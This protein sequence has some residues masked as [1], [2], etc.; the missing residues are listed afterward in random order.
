MKGIR[1]SIV[2]FLVVFADLAA[3]SN[4]ICPTARRVYRVNI[5]GLTQSYLE[6]KE[7][8]AKGAIQRVIRGF[9]VAEHEFNA[10]GKVHTSTYSLATGRVDTWSFRKKGDREAAELYYHSAVRCLP[11]E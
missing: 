10:E 6:I 3:A 11:E 9:P 2:V 5:T 4:W 1:L 8:D 7:L